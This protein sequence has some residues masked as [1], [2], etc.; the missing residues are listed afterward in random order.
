M[1]AA[2]PVF[3][4]PPFG[5]KQFGEPPAYRFQVAYPVRSEQGNSR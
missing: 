4:G 3:A 2:L 5:L 1:P